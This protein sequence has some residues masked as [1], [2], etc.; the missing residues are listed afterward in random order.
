MLMKN[1]THIDKSWL[2]LIARANEHIVMCISAFHGTLSREW[3]VTYKYTPSM[4]M[5]SIMLLG[6]R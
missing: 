6:A 2:S 3:W 1:P 5:C 4:R